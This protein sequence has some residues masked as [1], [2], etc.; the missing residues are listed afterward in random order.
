MEISNLVE[1]RL[2][3]DAEGGGIKTRGGG[4]AANSSGAWD[5]E[6]TGACRGVDRTAA[7]DGG[8]TADARVAVETTFAGGGTSA[9]RAGDGVNITGGGVTSI[10]VAVAFVVRAGAVRVA[11]N[12][13]GGTANG[14]TGVARAALSTS[15]DANASDFFCRSSEPCPFTFARGICGA[16]AGRRK[17]GGGVASPCAVQNEQA[18]GVLKPPPTGG[19]GCRHRGHALEIIVDLPHSTGR[20]MGAR[21][22]VRGGHPWPRQ[23]PSAAVRRQSRAPGSFVPRARSSSR[24]RRRKGPR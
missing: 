1:S 17:V 3:T 12:A 6:G 18:P 10:S 20:R 4:V 2:P 7:R 15:A 13:W 22:L 8:N 14:W 9:K 16:G 24:G 11:G 5:C 19:S 21:R 23:P